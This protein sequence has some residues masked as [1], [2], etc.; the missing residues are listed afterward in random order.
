MHQPFNNQGFYLL[1]SSSQSVQD[2]KKIHG[3]SS[4]SHQIWRPGRAGSPQFDAGCF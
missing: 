4:I 1:P 3:N 2:L